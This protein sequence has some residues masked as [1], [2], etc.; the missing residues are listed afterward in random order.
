M[1]PQLDNPSSARTPTKT[2]SSQTLPPYL[3]DQLSRMSH[4][5]SMPPSQ[6]LSSP[7]V[8]QEIVTSLECPILL[9]L[10]KQWPN[11]ALYKETKASGSLCKS[12]A[13]SSSRCVMVEKLLLQILDVVG[14]TQAIVLPVRLQMCKVCP[15]HLKNSRWLIWTI[16]S[17]LWWVAVANPDQQSD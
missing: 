15:N 11:R 3:S 8:A 13:T 1:W 5:P 4:H 7:L 12:E 16:H 9:A 2:S 10:R 17:Y 14:L 6:R